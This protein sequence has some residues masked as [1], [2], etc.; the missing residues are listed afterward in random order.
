MQKLLIAILTFGM[1]SLLSAQ[2]PGGVSVSVIKTAAIKKTAKSQ[3]PETEPFLSQTLA[4]LSDDQMRVAERVAVGK[5]PCELSNHVVVTADQRV[6]G[7]FTLEMGRQK[8]H[9]VPV[10]TSTGAI[11]LEDEATGAVWLQLANKSMLMNQ[12][13]GK[14][15][16]D[17]CVT[18]EQLVVAQA[19]ERSPGPQLLDVV[20]PAKAVFPEKADGTVQSATAATN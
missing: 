13:L 19:M 2:V 14:R 20:Q 12:K 18:P 1:S 3:R 15:L 17:A 9:M 5:I 11:R 7:H 4:T 8:F 6:A 16:A 10:T